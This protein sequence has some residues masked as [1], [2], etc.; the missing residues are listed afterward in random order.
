MLNLIKYHL[1]DLFQKHEIVFSNSGHVYF[2]KEMVNWIF[3]LFEFIK[4]EMISVS[5]HYEK[6]VFSLKSY[7]KNLRCKFK[8]ESKLSK[9]L[10]NI[11]FI[12]VK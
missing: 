12:R 7:Y 6:I 2:L 9:I 3:E 11:I 4:T 8:P 1:L 5:E 10:F